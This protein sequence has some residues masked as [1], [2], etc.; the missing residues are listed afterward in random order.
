MCGR[1][2]CGDRINEE[3]DDKWLV[4]GNT[5]MPKTEVEKLF[6]GIDVAS[7]RQEDV[8]NWRNVGNGCVE[9]AANKLKEKY[10]IIW[11]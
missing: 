10:G 2:Y 1:L 4:K 5:Q 11:D 3:D 8:L 6:G 9:F 7:N